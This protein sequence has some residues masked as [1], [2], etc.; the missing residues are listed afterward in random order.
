MEETAIYLWYE[1]RLIFVFMCNSNPLYD[2][3]IFDA[4][5]DRPL[6]TFRSSYAGADE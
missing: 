1:A 6:Q 5:Y 3:F 4:C 2:E